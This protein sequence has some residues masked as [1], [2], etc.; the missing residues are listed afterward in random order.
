MEIT[1][2]ITLSTA[3]VKKQTMDLLQ[4]VVDFQ[5]NLV[6][7][8]HPLHRLTVYE[9]AE[10]GFF[11]YNPLEPG[12]F[13]PEEKM[14]FSEDLMEIFNLANK[15]DCGLICLD[16]DGPVTPELKFYLP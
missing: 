11:I 4:D 1:K 2:M 12:T 7:E 6:S 13:D 3:H 10:Y 8:T 9:K 15:N 14:N 16:G 5:P